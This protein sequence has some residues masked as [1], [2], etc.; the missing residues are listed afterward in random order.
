MAKADKF[1]AR[2]RKDLLSN[3]IVM[4]GTDVN[5]DDVKAVITLLFGWVSSQL[6]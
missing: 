1:S 3:D 5:Y 6:M 4:T 2:R